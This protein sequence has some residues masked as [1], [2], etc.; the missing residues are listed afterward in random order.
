MASAFVPSTLRAGDLEPEFLQP[1]LK[2]LALP[3]LAKRLPKSPRVVNLAAMG[4]QP[5]Q[6]GGTLR[7]IIGSQKDIRMMTIYGYARLVGYDEKLN[8]QPDI[9]E[10][11]D[12]ADDRVFTFK[13]RE[14]HKWSNGSLLTPEDF[15]Y[16]WEDVWLNDELTQ[17]G[18]PPTLLVEG[19]PPRFE[20]VDPLTVRYSWDAPNPDFL[21]KLAAASPLSLVLPATYLKQFHKKYQDPFR[22]AGLMEENRAKKWTL[23]HI[24]M[25]R[26]Y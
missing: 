5:G 6:Y 7:T 12:V 11:F 24:R 3:A 23:L 4:R 15:R 21:P 17:G 16:C 8:L 25:S 26:Q 19:K 18:L 22:L 20:I 1:L 13:I 10:S 2:A 14:G 9:L